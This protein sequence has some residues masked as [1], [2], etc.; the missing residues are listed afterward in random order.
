M[1]HLIGKKFKTNQEA[2][3]QMLKKGVSMTC[4]KVTRTICL[5][6]LT[7]VSFYLFA[8]TT[9]SPIVLDRVVLHIQYR[10]YTQREVEIYLAVHKALEQKT[11]KKLELITK[12]SWQKDLDFFTT[13]TVILY[14]S[15]R[16]E[17]FQPRQKSVDES[18]KKI[19]QLA[20]QVASYRQW[21]ERIGADKAS[22]KATTTNYLQAQETKKNRKSIEK[23]SNKTLEQWLKKLK[24]NLLIRHYDEAYQYVHIRPNFKQ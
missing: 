12:S 4:Y 1:E 9:P 24:K 6:C 2:P 20:L 7:S 17:R 22:L 10:A 5:Y 15:Q 11:A 18:L 13:D 14:E 8:Q 19:E 21:L 3:K 23:I 16:L